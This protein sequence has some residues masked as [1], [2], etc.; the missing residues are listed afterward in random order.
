[1]GSMIYTNYGRW[2]PKDLE[3]LDEVVKN[4]STV[5]AGGI[6]YLIVANSTVHSLNPDATT[7]ADE[8]S[9]YPGLCDSVESGGLG[10]DMRYHQASGAFH[11][12]LNKS[13]EHWSLGELMANLTAGGRSGERVLQC[14]QSSRDYVVSKKPMK[15]AMLSWETLHTIA[16]GGVAPHVTELAGALN[17]A[18]HEVHIFTRAQGDSFTHEILGVHYHEV[19]YDRAGCLVQD[20]NNMCSAFICAL[21]GHESVWGP[22][23]IVHG[24]DWLAGPGVM[25]LKGQGKKVVFTMHSTEGGRNGDMGKG[26]PGIKN[27]E[28]QACGA[29]DKLICV[30]GVLKDE[31]CGVCGANGGKIDV[32]YNGIHAQPIVDM[33]WEDEWSG[34]AK[35]DKGFNRMDPTF[36]FVG[37]HTPQKGCDLF[38]EAIPSI[39]Q[40]RGDA[41]FIIVGDGHMFAHNQARCAA[42]GVGHAVRFTGSLKSGSEHLKALFKACDAVVVPS[43]NEP[44]GIV[45]LECW[46]AGKPVVATT[47]GGP[48]DFVKP[49][50]DGFLI[51][52]EPG[53]IAWGCC[54]I[55]ENMEHAKWMGMNAQAK[56][57]REFSWENIAKQTEQVYYSLLGLD[58]APRGLDSNAGKPLAQVLMKE[59]CMEMMVEHRN[60][61]VVRGIALLKIWKLLA[62]AVGNSVMT[63]MGSEFGQI[64]VVDMPRPANGFND[65]GSRTKY[66]LADNTDLKFSQLA[67]FETALNRAAQDCQWASEKCHKM[68]LQSEEDKV[69]VF[70]RGK[71]LFVLNLHQHATYENYSLSLPKGLAGTLQTTP[72]LATEDERFGGFGVSACSVEPGKNSLLLTLPPRSGFVF[73]GETSK[74]ESV[75]AGA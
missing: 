44:F 52:P 39:L 7:I 54:K 56:A 9:L 3:E 21:N 12:L 65:E 37:R 55:L 20:A 40:C 53:S 60:P 38:M 42:M 27:I 50:E 29:A 49:G 1:V 73:R 30:S 58:G 57:L 19:S 75:I 62:A 70:T 74:I 51:D 2:L 43:R 23:D 69:L 41:K 8:P 64:D 26:H 71:S 46:A 67:A 11:G 45:V 22:F 59:H 66:E 5:N 72:A 28:R 61:A 10:F 13:D 36:L 4:P 48:R 18:G 16:V 32:I 35:E 17:G 33:P 63:W 25:Q 34:N 14:S 47:S 24:H 68:V 6:H 15:I 31:V